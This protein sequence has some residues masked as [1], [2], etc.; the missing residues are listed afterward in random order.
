[1]A[2]SIVWSRKRIV[3]NATR[4]GSTKTTTMKNVFI[5]SSA[6]DAFSFCLRSLQQG[7]RNCPLDCT[8]GEKALAVDNQGQ[9][10]K[11]ES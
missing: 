10:D 7:S 2:V 5:S 11:D 9:H 6:I 4:L 3:Q 8:S 1:M